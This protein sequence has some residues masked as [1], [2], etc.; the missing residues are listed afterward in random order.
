[1]KK[2][3]PN[4]LILFITFLFIFIYLDYLEI[5]LYLDSNISYFI[6]NP[7]I[8]FVSIIIIIYV[9]ENISFVLSILILLIYLFFI[10]N[11]IRS[12]KFENLS[13]GGN[14]MMSSLFQGDSDTATEVID[15]ENFT[16]VGNTITEGA[17]TRQNNPIP[18]PGSSQTPK[19]PPPLY[20]NQ[21]IGPLPFRPCENTLTSNVPQGLPPS[22]SGFTSDPPGP[23]T[24]SAIGCSIGFS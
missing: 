7:L 17:H 11:S 4:C 16:P 6:S 15:G 2:N 24:D 13:N 12:N 18:P 10:N 21:Q 14:Y 23:Y 8:R 3:L 9:S 19:G 22:G 5:P 1:M 20:P